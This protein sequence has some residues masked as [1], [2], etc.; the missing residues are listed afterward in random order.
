[1][2]HKKYCK[3]VRPLVLATLVL[4]LV[5]VASAEWKESVLYSFQAGTDTYSPIGKV[6][7]DQAGNLYG[8]AQFGPQQGAVYQLARPAKA[9]DPWTE[10][11]L[12]TF[13]GNTFNDGQRPLGGLVIDKK[14]NLFGVTGYGGTG[15]CILLGIL[16]G[17]GAVYEISPPAQ[18]GGAWTETLI[19]SFLG[20]SDGDLPTGELTLDENGNLWGTT[21][22]GGGFGTCNTYFGYCG[23]VFKLTPP[24]TAG[25]TWTEQVLYSFKGGN[26]GANP[27]GG[28]IFDK[29]GA[30]YGTTQVGGST[31]LCVYVGFVGCG[32]VFQLKPPAEKGGSWTES[33]LHR[34]RSYPMD[35]VDPNGNLILQSGSLYGTTMGGGKWESGLIFKLAPPSQTGG[36]WTE[37]FIHE[38]NEVTGDLPSAGL[39]QDC[40]GNLYGT[41]AAGDPTSGG[42]IFR[43]YPPSPGG[44]WTMQVLYVF[45]RAPDGADPLEL[46]FGK[47]GAIYGTT[48]YGGTCT[49]FYGGCGTVFEMVQ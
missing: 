11:I 6:V 34:F 21:Q 42:S 5:S 36:R 17:C 8:A 35:G 48:G 13:K 26:D 38:F 20:G 43:L 49:A 9:G 47:D 7:L 23:T 2:N 24:Q 18:E 33:L 30:I 44:K 19:Y 10:T 28:L 3:F 39:V 27:N 32:T 4:A 12:Y 15:P 37:T 46:T 22:Y 41:L 40:L 45:T 1:M 29:E 14:G 31:T 25:G 16:E